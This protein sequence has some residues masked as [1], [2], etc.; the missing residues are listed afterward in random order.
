M[1]K[2][3]PENLPEEPVPKK[4]VPKKKL[5]QKRSADDL[6][7]HPFW[8]WL[9]SLL[10]VL[11]LTAV[12][13]AP[14][15]LLTPV[16]LPPGYMPPIDAMGRPQPL[17]PPESVVWQHPV[18]T[19]GLHGFFHNYLNLL[20]LN[21]GY[22]F[23]APDPAGTHVIDYQVTQA[24]GK[25]IEGRLPSL[26]EHWPRLLY[27]RHMM[28]AEQT[29]LMEQSALQYAIHLATLYGG[30]SQME[31]KMHLLLPPH[32]VADETPLDAPSTFQSIGIVTGHPRPSA[33]TN[34]P[35][36][37]QATSQQGGQQ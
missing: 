31:L 20:Y 34:L 2:K 8:R 27:H 33:L 15:D 9:V 22:E 13:S 11:H 23:F 29:Q 26:D 7:W 5:A 6:P 16:A 3:R 21:H 4:P 1:A 32:R 19:R 30:V 25:V 37:Q 14:W 35:A 10:V 18:I 17:P 28:L 24:D 12:F 36:P